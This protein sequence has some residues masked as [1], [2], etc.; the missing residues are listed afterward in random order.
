MS[1]PWEK[2]D[3]SD[4][5]NHM[6]LNSVYQLQ[7]LSQIMKEQFSICDATTVMILGIA[8]GNGLEHIQPKRFQTVYGVDVNRNYLSICSHRYPS[9]DGIFVPIWCDLQSENYSLP[10]AELVIANLLIEYIGYENFQRVIQSVTPHYASCVIQVNQDNGFVS[11]SPYL[12]TFGRLEEVHREITANELTKAM[13]MIKYRQI[14]KKEFP[15]PNGKALLRID[16]TL[17]QKGEI[18]HSDT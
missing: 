7:T 12:S 10:T 3:L 15:L 5:E 9:I 1:N 4:Y 11:D 6:K 18:K 14:Y 2:I 16:F 8:G 13:S 17:K